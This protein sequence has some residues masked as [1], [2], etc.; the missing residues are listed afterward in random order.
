[1]NKDKKIEMLENMVNVLENKTQHVKEYQEAKE[2]LLVLIKETK[3]L[4]KE[5]NKKLDYC[6]HLIEELKEAIK[7]TKKKD[8]KLFARH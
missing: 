5:Y 3:A 7:R 2:Q 1:M 4:K 8:V 6:N